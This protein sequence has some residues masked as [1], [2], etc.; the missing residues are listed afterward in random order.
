MKEESRLKVKE[1]AVQLGLF[2]FEKEMILDKIKTIDI[3]NITPMD[4][5][6]LLY[7]LNS[8]VKELN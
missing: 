1:D 5:M 6:K 4:A 8:D 2:D 3:M 7:E